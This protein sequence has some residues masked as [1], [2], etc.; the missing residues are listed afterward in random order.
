MEPKAKTLIER[1]GFL[2]PDRKK[3]KHDEIQIWVYHNFRSI[4]KHVFPLLKVEN[5]LQLKI[6]LEYPVADNSKHKNFIV[7]FVDVYCRKYSIGVEIKTEMP[8]V[9]ELIR[10]IQFYRNYINGS[11]IVVSPDDRNANI[12]KGQGIYFYKYHSA[13]VDQLKL[14]Q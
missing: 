12:L 10:Q 8:V 1:L 7:G 6:E 2:D 3:Y 14:F 4:I 13:D 9:G 11:W 5:D